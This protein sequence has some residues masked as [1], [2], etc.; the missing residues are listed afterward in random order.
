MIALT[1][2]QFLLLIVVAIA[3][4]FVIGGIGFV[5]FSLGGTLSG[6]LKDIWIF[7]LNRGRW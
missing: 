2:W 6:L 1:W 5:W 4:A 3:I 7:T